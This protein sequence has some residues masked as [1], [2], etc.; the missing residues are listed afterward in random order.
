[1]TV[2]TPLDDKAILAGKLIEMLLQTDLLNLYQH[3]ENPH[4]SRLNI[5]TKFM[6]ACHKAISLMLI[7]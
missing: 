5:L 1:M 2:A 4:R 6:M 3:R 7:S